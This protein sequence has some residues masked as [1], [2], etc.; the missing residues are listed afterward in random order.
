M[1]TQW[2]TFPVKFE[3]GLITNQGRLEQG[4]QFPGSATQ[5]QNYE[6][7]IQGGY[8]KVLGF[9]KFSASVVPGSGIVFSVIALANNEVLALRSNIYQYGTGGAWTS[10]NTL[11]V[12]GVVRTNHSSFDFN[13]NKNTVIVDSVNAPVVFNH[14]TKAMTYL[15]SPPPEIVGASL[16]RVFKNHVFFAK[17]RSLSFSAPYNINDFTPAN[18]AGII[19]IGQ[20]ITGIFVFRD[21]LIIFSLNS[22]S[23]LVGNSVGDFSL[24]SITTNTGCL[25]GQTIQEVG[26]DLIYLGPDGLRYLSASE[27]LN[28]FG[29]VRASEKIQRDIISVVDPNCMYSSVTIAGKNQYR[30]FNYMGNVPSLLT[31]AFL[32]TKFSNQT[33]DDISWG[34]LRGFKVYALSKYQDR[35][36]EFIVFS[37]DANFVFIMESGASLDGED[38]ESIFETPYMAINDPKIRKT[39]YKHTLYARPTG[40]F[41]INCTLLFDYRQVGASPSPAFNIVGG[42]SVTTYGSSN[43]IYGVSVYGNSVEEQYY[44]N[45]VGSGFVVALRYYDKSTNPTH[46]LNFATLEFRQNE[47]R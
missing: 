36:T 6:P 11:P 3:G 18:G 42:G 9:S 41:N 7:S 39:I 31:E 38:I 35:G 40:T 4:L 10:K 27:R 26:G 17:G 32:G 20:D 33:A 5:L 46:N 34:K 23:R 28:D 29:L 45:T 21:Q 24:Q 2:N 22:I 15:A 44:G 8:S 47:R 25:C 1:A 30:L 12:G 14:T 13:G 19:N 37:N 43:A 16:V